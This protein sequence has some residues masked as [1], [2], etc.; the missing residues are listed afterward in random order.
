M[1]IRKSLT[2]RGLNDRQRNQDGTLRQKRGDTHLGTIEKQYGELSPR[3]SDAH[4]DTILKD[5]GVDS[6]TAMLKERAKA[7]VPGKL[8]DVITIINH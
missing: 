5:Y 7:H 8:D 6:L 1:G 3:R 2:S 4:L